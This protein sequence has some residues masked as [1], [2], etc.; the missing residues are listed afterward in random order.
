MIELRGIKKSFGKGTPAEVKAL[1]NVNLELR[2]GE[3]VVLLGSNGSGKSTLM[4]VI[5]GSV[6]ADEGSIM[7]NGADVTQIP[8]YKRSRWVARIFQ[9]P[10]A[11]TSSDLSI[12]E[13]FRLASLRTSSKGF[14]IGTGKSFRNTIKEKVAEL[15]LGL[16]EKLDQKMGT[17]SG[18]QRQ[19]L[20]L[21][22]AVMDQTGILLMDEPTAALD[23]KTSVRIM[24]LAERL[25][26]QHK[27]TA[28]LI[29]HHLKDALTYG[30][31]IIMMD[32]GR[33]KKDVQQE[34][35]KEL[36]ANRLLEWFGV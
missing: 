9:Q 25:I 19:A 16:E 15:G 22:M 34:D 18:G 5:A 33:I 30:D 8:D 29:T 6:F 28:I 11:G 21:L 36:D 10:T 26:R 17:L 7:I 31:R 20:T 27:L 24:E 23:P 1:E 35:R 32:E 12:L 13:N 14:G 3:Y 2:E 4:N